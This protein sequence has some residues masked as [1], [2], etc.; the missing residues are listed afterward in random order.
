MSLSI[1]LNRRTL[2]QRV[3]YRIAQVTGML[4]ARLYTG[5]KQGRLTWGFGQGVGSADSELASELATLRQ[6]SRQLIRDSAYARRARQIVV[7]NV[8]GAGIDLQAQVMTTDGE[9]ATTV[10]DAIENGWR[11]WTRAE[12]CH[13]GGALAFGDCRQF[14]NRSL[15]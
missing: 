2:L 12:N 14:T 7:N 13:T 10:N 3:A 15:G 1:A 9:L 5:A 11:E 6:R 8:I 4:G